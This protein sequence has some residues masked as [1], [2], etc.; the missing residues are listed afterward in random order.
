L[1]ALLGWHQSGRPPGRQT[2]KHSSQINNVKIVLK[3][4]S[5]RHGY[6]ILNFSCNLLR[7]KN[8]M[9][10][11]CVLSQVYKSFLF[12]SIIFIYYLLKHEKRVK[13]FFFIAFHSS[14]VLTAN[15]Y[16]QNKKKKK[17]TKNII[18]HHEYN[19]WSSKSLST[20]KT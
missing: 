18:F 12:F 17:A 6:S 5:R 7:N 16:K 10:C 2:N 19:C 15:V 4:S 13:T 11:V 20:L 1:D 8:K 3:Y 9:T 14:F